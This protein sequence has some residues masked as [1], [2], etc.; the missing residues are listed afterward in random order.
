M[1]S[2]VGRLHNKQLVDS[3]SKDVY[4]GNSSILF[5]C[6]PYVHNA[7]YLKSKWT[8]QLRFCLLMPINANEVNFNAI[9]VTFGRWQSRQWISTVEPAINF[10]LEKW[11]KKLIQW[12]FNLLFLINYLRIQLTGKYFL[13]TFDLLTLDNFSFS[14]YLP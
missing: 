1:R 6:L 3:S 2:S 7:A 11:E 14:F 4:A 12:L 5:H 13:L 10:A 8:T 9:T